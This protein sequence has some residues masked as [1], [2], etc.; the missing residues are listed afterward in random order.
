MANM[1]GDYL[2]V[3]GNYLRGF[4]IIE[5]FKK[6]KPQDLKNTAKEFLNKESRSVVIVRPQPKTTSKG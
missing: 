6:I 2:M 1:L 4:E 3:S 5:E